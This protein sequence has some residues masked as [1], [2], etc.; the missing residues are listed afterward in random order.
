MPVEAQP[1]IPDHMLDPL[2][3]ALALAKI[4]LVIG[5]L[6]M[7]G[8]P[9]AGRAVITLAWTWIA[10]HFSGLRSAGAINMEAV[11]AFDNGRLG[12]DWINAVHSIVS[13]PLFWFEHLFDL[14]G[15]VALAWVVLSAMTCWQLSQ[16]TRQL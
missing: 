9:I 4:Q 13:P 3:R 12:S 1:L 11:A 14:V 16:A 7:I 15:L 8:A 2:R 6:L 5:F 10:D